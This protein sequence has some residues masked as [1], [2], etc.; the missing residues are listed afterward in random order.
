[1]KPSA[2]PAPVDRSLPLEVIDPPD[3][4]M[5]ETMSDDGLEAL[6]ASLRALGQLQN[7]VVVRTGDRFRVA[8]GHRRRVALEKA[9]FTAARCLVFPEGTPLEEA[10]KVDENGTQERV[11]PAAEATYYR[12]LLDNRCDGDVAKLAA[13]VRRKES[14]VLDRLDLTRGDEAVLG[15]LRRGEISLAVAQELNRV[16]ADTY[17]ALFLDDARRQGANATTVRRWRDELQRTLHIQQAA[18]ANQANPTPPSSESALVSI[19]ECPLCHSAADP[20]EMEY[21][22]VHRSCRAV[23]GRQQHAGGEK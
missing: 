14:F 3:V 18:A 7:L 4:A 11:N 23:F 19:D 22:R 9:G 10:I 13:L 2:V 6:V 16:R 5:R 21:V 17:R 15:A 1:M 20:H 12:W 8:A